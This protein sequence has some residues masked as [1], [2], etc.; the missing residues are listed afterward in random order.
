MSKKF[1]LIRSDRDVRNEKV[2]RWKTNLIS[3]K[4][5]EKY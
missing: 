1:S 5:I 3:I 4:G 2:T